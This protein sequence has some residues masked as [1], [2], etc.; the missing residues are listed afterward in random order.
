LCVALAMMALGFVIDRFNL[1][2]RMLPRQVGSAPHSS[3]YSFWS[4]TVLVLGGSLMAVVAAIR[5]TG[6]ELRF[7]REG[8]GAPGHGLP[9]G[10]LFTLFVAVIGVVVAIFLMTVR[11]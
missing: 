8:C 1:V 2:L 11:Y 3:I 6:L 10:V 4:G 9:L 7:R 5:Y